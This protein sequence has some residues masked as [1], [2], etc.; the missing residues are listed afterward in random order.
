MLGL[1]PPPHLTLQLADILLS[2]FIYSID[3]LWGI[4]KNKHDINSQPYLRIYPPFKLQILAS[5]LLIMIFCASTSLPVNQT[6]DKCTLL[7]TSPL[8]WPPS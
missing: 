1:P 7:A 4:D 2:V 5:G 3:K 6:L 8:P